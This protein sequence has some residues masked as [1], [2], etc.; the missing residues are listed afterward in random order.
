ML[1]FKRKTD[2]RGFPT[3]HLEYH[4]WQAD[5]IFI[6]YDRQKLVLINRQISLLW[7]PKNIHET[8]Y[9]QQ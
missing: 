3:E 7:K 8:Q 9:I 1:M 2:I 5:K 6:I 4:N